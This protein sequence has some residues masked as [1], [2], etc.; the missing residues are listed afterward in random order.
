MHTQE[1][2]K[3]SDEALI[4]TEAREKTVIEERDVE[5]EKVQ[6]LRGNIVA[7]KGTLDAANKEILQKKKVTLCACVHDFVCAAHPSVCMH[8]LFL[9]VHL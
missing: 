4:Q 2:L 3:L 9:H 5:R 7:V 6:D 1:Q 8:L